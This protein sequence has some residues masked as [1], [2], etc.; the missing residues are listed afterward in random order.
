MK[1]G[2]GTG[3]NANAGGNTRDAR[4]IGCHVG[5]DQGRGSRNDGASAGRKTNRGAAVQAL[6]LKFATV[7]LM[8]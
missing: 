2:A 7:L 8:E 4:E 5:V 1:T 3:A 6:K